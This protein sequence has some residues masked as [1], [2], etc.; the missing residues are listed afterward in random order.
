MLPLYR[1]HKLYVAFGRTI[2][3]FGKSISKLETLWLVV[4]IFSKIDLYIRHIMFQI[5]DHGPMSA[6]KCAFSGFALF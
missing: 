5:P 3:G 1:A 6:Y 2:K 4:I